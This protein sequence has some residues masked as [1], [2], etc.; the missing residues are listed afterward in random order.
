MKL[1]TKNLLSLEELS[2]KEISFIIDLG[3]K[4]KKELKKGGH[5]PILKNK[6]LVM[7]FQ[8]PSTRTRVSFEIG[9]FQLGG[10]ALNMSSN[11]MQLSR[12]DGFIFCSAS[13]TRPGAP[14][15]HRQTI[16]QSGR[17]FTSIARQWFVCNQ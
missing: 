4:L 14:S 3:I 6:T 1:Q 12:G 2:P 10:Y 16:E 11:D 17:S 15:C 5:K 7:I 9:M 8:K 13:R